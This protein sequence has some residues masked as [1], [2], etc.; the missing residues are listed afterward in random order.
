[1]FCYSLTYH[2]DKK[3]DNLFLLPIFQGDA[4][5]PGIP[6]L[7]GPKGHRVGI[8]CLKTGDGFQEIPQNITSH[9]D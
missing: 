2:L 4:G 9:Q 6:G 8:K 1:M 3:T 5:R 7:P